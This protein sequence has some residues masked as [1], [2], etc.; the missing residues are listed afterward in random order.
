MDF[1]L[2]IFVIPWITFLVCRTIYRLSFHPLARFPGPKLAAVTKWYETYFELVQR[3]GGQ[4]SREI[5]RMHDHYGVCITHFEKQ[6]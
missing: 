3:P 6:D 2:H 5:D 4:Y 1:S